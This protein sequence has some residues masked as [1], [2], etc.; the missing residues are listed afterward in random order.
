MADRT[1]RE[2]EIVLNSQIYPIQGFVRERVISPF[3]A[4]VIVGDNE[5]ANEQILSNW[6]TSDQRG[7]MLIENM[8][9]STDAD[10][11]WYSTAWT[12]QKASI[13]LPPLTTLV[14]APDA[15]VVPTS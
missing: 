9:E 15:T 14:S 2:N 5:F 10:R 6:I 1:I 3:P 13:T 4:K 8:D 7:G 12:R 11:Y